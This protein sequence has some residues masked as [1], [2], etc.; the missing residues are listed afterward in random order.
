MTKGLIPS[1]TLALWFL[2]SRAIADPVSAEGRTATLLMLN[3][4]YRIGGV[5]GGEAG[6]LPRLRTLRTELEREAPDLLVLH[7][8]DLLFPSTLSRRYGGAQMIDLLNRLDGDPNAFDPRLWVTFGNHE[9]ERDRREQAG[10]LA[11]RIR[12]S[13]FRWLGSNLIF[14]QDE[15]GKPLV[16]AENLFAAALVVTGGIRIGLFSLT[17]DMNHPEY[18]E[19]FE[20]P[21]QVARRMTALLRQQGAEVVVALTHQRMSA[22][23]ALLQGLGVQGPDLIVGG[24]EH[25]RQTQAASAHRRVIK[26]DAD[27]RSAGLVRIHLDS[28]GGIRIE[29][30]FRLLDAAVVPDPALLAQVREWQGRFDREVCPELREPAGCLDRPVGHTRVA[31]EAEELRIRRFETN[32]GNFVADQALAAF[33][34]R[35]AQIAFV[36]GG[37]LRLNEDLPAGT[38]ITRSHLLD[39]F[40]YRTPLVLLRL[41]GA[42][43]GKIAERA[44][45]DWT[46]NGWWLQIAGFAFRHHPDTE[47]ISD[48]TLLTPEGPRPVRPDEEILAVTSDFLSNPATGQDG[49]SMIDPAARLTPVEGAP[50]LRAL[51]TKALRAAEP[52]GI[53][54]ERQGRICNLQRPGP[55][56]ALGGGVPAVP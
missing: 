10:Q 43:L 15:A 3:D 18:L 28:A 39:L 24:H 8:G 44:V 19:T 16:S 29:T 22:D 38:L 4:T 53:A 42:T 35:G 27:A 30:E 1:L 52:E 21:T 17:G 26:A 48:L 37:A 9:F 5:D 12:E 23:L 13:R 36:N 6:G 50:D 51:V 55:C 20:D 7:A 33:A 2:V 46:G 45:Q 31:L 49:Y 34:D 56:L 25:D 41:D 14:A 11:A 40:A 32:L 54:P 47:G